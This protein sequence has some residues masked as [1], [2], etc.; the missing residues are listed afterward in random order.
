MECEEAARLRAVPGLNYLAVVKATATETKAK[1][2]C[3]E[4]GL[5]P[6]MRNRTRAGRQER[7]GKEDEQEG[8]CVCV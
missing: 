7:E 8:V 1:A 3:V 4:H 2:L 6:S 5:L